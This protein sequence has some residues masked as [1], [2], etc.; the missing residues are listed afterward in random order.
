M[1][2]ETPDISDPQL[3]TTMIIACCLSMVIRDWNE[4]MIT[5]LVQSLTYLLNV[6]RLE[7]IEEPLIKSLL[8]PYY[9]DVQETIIKDIADSKAKYDG[10]FD[11]LVKAGNIPSAVTE[12]LGEWSPPKFAD[13]FIIEDSE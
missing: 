8:G 12:I 4:H 1:E 3:A 5:R 13:C 11:R 10:I 7:G 6:G 2:N 9:S